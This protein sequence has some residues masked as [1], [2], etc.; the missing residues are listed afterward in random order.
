M[1]FYLL[2]L[3]NLVLLLQGLLPSLDFSWKPIPSWIWESIFLFFFPLSQGSGRMDTLRNRTVEELREL[4]DDS[5]EIE[6]LALESQEVCARSRRC[7]WAV[8]VPFPTLP[9]H[10]G[11]H[12]CRS[13]SWKGRWPWLPTGAWPSRT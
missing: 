11:F 6:R 2:Y 4:Q 10:P 8:L 12:R 7:L 3:Q 13:C 1:L 5:Q 9:H